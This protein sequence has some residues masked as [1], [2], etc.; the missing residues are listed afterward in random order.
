MTSI[1]NLGVGSGLDL[2]SLL[3]QLTTAEQAPLNAIKAQ[4]ASSQTKLSAYGT[5]QSVL[6]A[7]QAAAKQLADPSFF[8]GTTATSSNTGVLTATGGSKATS[9]TYAV[10]V[11][12]LAQAQSLVAAGQAS[13][14]AALTTGTIH[15]DFGTITDAAGGSLDNNA[16]SP[17]YGRYS[18]ATFAATAGSSGIDIKIDSTNNTL[19]GVSDAINKANTGVTASIVNDGS[20]TPYRLVLTAK[21]TG[22]ASSMRI[23]VN[24]EAGSGTSL[25]GLVSYD[26]NNG[27][28]GQRMQQSIVAQNA[29]L[30]VNNIAIQSASN[31]VT[32][33]L[34]GVTLA[35]TQTGNTSVAIQRDTK[36]IQTGVQSFVSA[37]NNLQSVAASLTAY[38]PSTKTGSPLTGDG[39]LRI[40]QSQIRGILNMPQGSGSGANAINTL[41]QAGISFQTDGSIQ[42]DNVTLTNALNSNAAGVAGLFGNTD[43]KSGYGNQINALVTSLTGTNGALTSATNDV[44]QTLKDLSDQYTSKSD[45]VDATIANYKAQFTQL[46][47]IMAQM[48]NTSSYL[49][50]QFNAMNNT[51]NK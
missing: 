51:S 16:A 20:G 47:T 11:S 30:T 22:A 3:D 28:G 39:T 29:Q 46:D 25:A 10:N 4:Q 44:N 35:L 12:A 45:L 37:Y 2:S 48:N 18:N 27:S 5:L 36:T 41:S 13:Q 26:V 34:P 43:G 24:N 42:L 15:I 21:D 1:S 40:I 33:A 32:D 19:Q 23:K 9:G 14:T 6:G 31:N 17:T 38:D 7:F 50:Q 49:T 8:N